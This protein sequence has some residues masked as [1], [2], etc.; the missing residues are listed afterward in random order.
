MNLPLSGFCE[1]LEATEMMWIVNLHHRSRW[2]CLAKQ[3]S[4]I[5]LHFQVQENGAEWNGVERSLGNGHIGFDNSRTLIMRDTSERD[6]GLHET[7]FWVK[8]IFDTSQSCQVYRVNI[9]YSSE[10]NQ[11]HSEVVQVLKAAVK[12]RK[13]GLLF[14]LFSDSSCEKKTSISFQLQ[15]SPLTLEVERKVRKI[16]FELMIPFINVPMMTPQNIAFSMKTSSPIAKMW[17]STHTS[18]KGTKS[19]S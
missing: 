1:S 4:L 13:R 5:P 15:L 9:G 10:S 7:D 2:T 8:I 14:Y 18:Q 6:I 17:Y 12:P 19:K 3:R 11:D 16:E